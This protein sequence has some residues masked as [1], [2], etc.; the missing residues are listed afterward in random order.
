MSEVNV[1][2][3]K[4]ILGYSDDISSFED[5]LSK[6][7]EKEGL[8]KELEEKFSIDFFR[9]NGL[10]S[11]IREPYKFSKDQIIR[12][13]STSSQV[14]NEHIEN[15]LNK[16]NSFSASLYIASSE[17]LSVFG[18][19]KLVEKYLDNIHNYNILGGGGIVAGI[20]SYFYGRVKEDSKAIGSSQFKKKFDEVVDYIGKDE[21]KYLLD[22]IHGKALTAVAFN[23]VYYYL[24]DKDILKEYLELAKQFV[25]NIPWGKLGDALDW[26]LKEYWPVERY[27]IEILGKEEVMNT[28]RDSERPSFLVDLYGYILYKTRVD[29]HTE[30]L[31]DMIST[32]QKN[33]V[34][35]LIIYLIASASSLGSDLLSELLDK[36]Y[37]E[38]NELI[39]LAI[40]SKNSFRVPFIGTIPKSSRR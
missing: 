7:I 18:D 10:Q 27:V 33:G 9:T 5:L 3:W 19:S 36:L 31:V 39:N 21:L 8:P 24:D 16:F 28:I 13:L 34:E 1:D 40:Y 15:I 4:G 32:S 17:V 30:K 29:D 14:G 25:A 6:I 26:Q 11:N 2:Y 22:N 12:I 35:D 37:E 38:K 23:S 20:L